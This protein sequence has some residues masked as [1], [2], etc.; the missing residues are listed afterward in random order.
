MGVSRHKQNLADKRQRERWGHRLKE[1][2][3]GSVIKS[4]G[5]LDAKL[6][7]EGHMH[8]R[9]RAE[10]GRVKVGLHGVAH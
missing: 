7:E 2:K 8:R 9:G 3:I 5:R 4:E 1:L 6:D 10:H